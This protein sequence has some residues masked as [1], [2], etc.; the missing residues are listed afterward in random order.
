MNKIQPIKLPPLIQNNNAKV[1]IKKLP[2]LD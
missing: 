1:N 2:P